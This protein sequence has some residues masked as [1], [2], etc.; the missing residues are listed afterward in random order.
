MPHGAWQAMGGRQSTSGKRHCT[1]NRSQ[2]TWQLTSNLQTQCLDFL[3]LQP[4]KKTANTLQPWAKKASEGNLQLQMLCEHERQI[5]LSKI[6]VFADR[7]LQ[8]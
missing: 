2:S 7:T 8:N 1:T 5:T 4:T 3:A 6:S